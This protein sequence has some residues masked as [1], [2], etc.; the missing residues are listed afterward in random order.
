MH[1]DASLT[2]FYYKNFD[3][4][5]VMIFIPK[6]QW[7]W[8]L[9][10]NLEKVWDIDLAFKCWHDIMFTT[11]ATRRLGHWF[12]HDHHF[13]F[14]NFEVWTLISHVHVVMTVCICIIYSFKMLKIKNHS[15]LCVS[16][17]LP[18]L[19]W[20]EGLILSVNRWNYSNYF[21]YRASI[22]SV[23]FVV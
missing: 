4:S 19:F 6:L 10:Q 5:T 8:F 9:F 3:N 7:S 23:K 2:E 22:A 15:L 11:K 20:L 14:K 13:Y 16:N 18:S 1:I 17:N 21:I 12:C